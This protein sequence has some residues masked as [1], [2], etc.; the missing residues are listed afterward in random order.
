MDAQTIII[1]AIIS[2]L[3]LLTLILLLVRRTVVATI[4]GFYWRRIVQLEHYI[5][6][7]ESSYWGFPEG[8][9]DQRR[10]TETYLVSQV[11][12]S[13]T[14]T[15]TDANGNTCTHTEP[16]YAMVPHTRTK[17]LYEIQRWRKSREL[18]TEGDDRTRVYW[19]S[20]TLDHQTQE[21]IQTAR[22]LYKVIFQTAKGKTY[23]RQLPEKEWTELDEQSAYRLRIT[24]FGK[25]TRFVPQ[26]EQTVTVPPQTH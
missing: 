17:Y 7:S 14:R 13:T 20:Y 8:S 26:P 21:R 16:V 6:V 18:V 22:G 5:W 24:L 4:A 9:R 11:V 23:R 2:A 15:T 12:G 10:K 3:L 19:P 25:V 1:I